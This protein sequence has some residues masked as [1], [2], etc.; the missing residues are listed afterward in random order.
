MAMLALFATVALSFV[1]YAETEA[2]SSRLASQGEA[3][4]RADVDPEM[5]L[6]YFLNQF[7][8]DTDNIYSAMRGHS[9]ARNIYG[10]N[11]ADINAIPF[12]GVGRKRFPVS[13]DKLDGKPA[14]PTSKDNM[15]LI[16]YQNYSNVQGVP[17]RDPE[18]DENGNYFAG[19][20][21]WTYPDLNNM[22]LAAVNADGTVLVP[23][24][25]RPW[26]G[27]NFTGAGANTDPWA[28]YMTLRPHPSHHPRFVSPDWDEGGDVKNLEW[29]RGT[30]TLTGTYVNNDS[31][32]M[33]LGFP[34]LTAPNGKRYKAL[35]APL[36][37][38]LDNKINLSVHGNIMNMNNPEDRNNPHFSNEGWGWWEV[39]PAKVLSM[40]FQAAQG[41][42]P[43]IYGT[44][45]T[46]L[47]VGPIGR[48]G[49]DGK[50]DN[51]GAN[52]MNNSNIPPLR[53]PVIPPYYSPIDTG[54][55]KGFSV[56]NQKY[57]YLPGDP[58]DPAFATSR[59]NRIRTFPGLPPHWDNGVANDIVNHASG[60][61]PFNPSTTGGK[62]DRL[63]LALSQLEGLYRFGGT[64]SPAMTND[65]IANLPLNMS[66]P[67]IRWLSTLRSMDLDRPG[68]L[69]YNW[70]DLARDPKLPSDYRF[71]PPNNPATPYPVSS[72]ATFPPTPATGIPPAGEF[73][74]SGVASNLY[75]KAVA[76]GGIDQLRVLLNRNLTP[77]PT[78]DATGLITNLVQYQ[79][80][81]SDRQ[82]MA[83]E[84]Y[85]MLV[86][87]TGA[88]DPRLVAGMDQL[89]DVT[90][91]FRAARWLAQLALNIVDFIDEDDYMTPWQW[92][93][94]GNAQGYQPET[95]FGTELPHLLLNEIYA[96]VDND[97][98][99]KGLA[100]AFPPKA[101]PPVVPAKA[102]TNYLVNFWVELYN[103]M[104]RPNGS[105][106][107]RD[108][109]AA[110][111]QSQS[112]A[113]YRVV[114]TETGASTRLNFNPNDPLNAI[115][116]L[117]TIG[118]DDPPPPG[119]PVTNLPRFGVADNFPVGARVVDVSDRDVAA[120]SN[121]YGTDP[122]SNKG[123]YVLGPDPLPNAPTKKAW[124]DSRDPK[125]LT[126][127]KFKGLSLAYPVTGATPTL[128][129]LL[130][131]PRFAFG[132]FLQRLA[133]P[134]MPFQKDPTKPYYNPY[135]TIDYFD[136]IKYNATAGVNPPDNAIWEGRLYDDKGPNAAWAKLDISKFSSIGRRRPYVAPQ[137]ATQGVPTTAPVLQPALNWTQQNPEKPL[138][139]R[140]KN[141]F[142]SHNG[143]ESSLVRLNSTIPVTLDLPF[144]WPVHMDRQL[145][146]PLEL[147]NVSCYRPW[148][149]T[150]RFGLGDKDHRAPW[151]DP[152]TLL[153]RLFEMTQT[154]YFVSPNNKGVLGGR[155]FG[156][157]NLNTIWDI[158]ILDALVDNPTVDIQ[159]MF[160]SFMESR[161]PGVLAIT[162]PDNAPGAPAPKGFNPGPTDEI[163]FNTDRVFLASK[164]IMNKPFKSTN[165]GMYKA[166]PGTQY[167]NGL[168]M[169][170]TILRRGVFHQSESLSGYP[171]GGMALKKNEVLTKIFNNVTT[172]SNVFAVWLTVGFFEVVDETVYPERLGAEIGRSENRHVRHRMFAIIDRTNLMTP[173]PKSPQYNQ[174][175]VK[176][177]T[178]LN[179]GPSRQVA[180]SQ[181][182]WNLA[183]N[184]P[185]LVNVNFRLRP[186]MTLKIGTGETVKI[187][188][189]DYVSKQ[190]TV[191]VANN[192][193]PGTVVMP[194]LS[195]SPAALIPPG[196]G[197]GTPVLGTTAGP[198]ANPVAIILGNP[199]TLSGSIPT[200]PGQVPSS[201]LGNPG[202][203]D[204][205]DPRQNTLLV[206]HFSIIQ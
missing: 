187:Q 185:G 49:A 155:L 124:L 180:L 168:G 51:P 72:G 59:V 76:T 105:L 33:D 13:H 32:W 75:N 67:R 165:V 190:V 35:F 52:P 31:I 186:G 40:P 177:T 48:Y 64:G 125:L 11:P 22:F 21:H 184:P 151:D 17:R 66:F 39:N 103:P 167:P 101:L 171:G 95:L 94:I 77:Y 58:T 115:G 90:L 18:R 158:E 145:V 2:T 146:N 42:K 41:G 193:P 110:V 86:K 170:N 120:S 188:D 74:T 79:R 199:N 71:N 68:L 16:N 129:K 172:R 195:T 144:F 148:E 189:V 196:P 38:D 141:T 150:Q 174:F 157:I 50:P 6:A 119:I 197:I 100:A 8:F 47:F 175:Q 44:E 160:K 7:I 46:K 87:L 69:A 204:S 37:V 97:A 28:K 182:A 24:F 19:N 161:S 5:L 82:N 198:V 30:R 14:N 12:N 26:L 54:G 121:P 164:A 111:L 15:L 202:P 137:T 136:R 84:L 23:S 73:A 36:A 81:V 135:I 178:P 113:N 45:W 65:L 126:S 123:F 60:Y 128:D 142:F 153:Y 80:A 25:Y 61:D 1:F 139:N 140:P 133:N 156:K 200:T 92:I 62:D 96:Q 88:R 108:N 55:L 122:V 78:Y 85:N 138:A 206:P 98:T 192:Y 20:V 147:L 179:K 70:K 143:R 83:L 56:A 181:V 134:N 163:D 34:V 53:M 201:I 116:K 93:P 191:T 10:Y 102:T 99:D 166:Q 9:L 205:F 43:P 149:Y 89:K 57:M 63:P 169:E 159:L 154:P 104:Q 131:D 114:V 194:I 27:V 162:P 3:A 130:N 4:A 91:E 183:S 173:D 109:G 107:P 152:N 203:Q 118:P 176:T 106:Y 29:G 112:Q 117:A 127:A 132:V